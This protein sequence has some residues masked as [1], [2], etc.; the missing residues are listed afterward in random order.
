MDLLRE[1]FPSGPLRR[2]VAESHAALAVLFMFSGKRPLTSNC[3]KLCVSDDL[4]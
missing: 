2:L 3:E 1:G 4:I